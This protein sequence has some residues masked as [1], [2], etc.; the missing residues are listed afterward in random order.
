MLDNK[1]SVSVLVSPILGAVSEESRQVEKFGSQ[2]PLF[3]VFNSNCTGSFISA[4]VE[5]AV[6]NVDEN[7]TVRK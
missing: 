4:N 3:P 7:F 5:A 6:R 1:L 2:L